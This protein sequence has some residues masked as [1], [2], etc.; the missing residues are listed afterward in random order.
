MKYLVMECH[1][2]YAVVLD[3]E[4]RFLKVANLNYEVGQTVTD[5]I[6][7][8][9]P[10]EYETCME[11]KNEVDSEKPME[12]EESISI[13]SPKIH[14]MNRWM[15]PLVAA[16]ACLCFLVIVGGQMLL[17]PYGSVEMVINPD[18]MI[19]VNR[20]DYVIDVEGLNQDGQDLVADYE[21]RFKKIDQVS[22]ELADRA[23][24]MGYLTEGGTIHLIVTGGKEE[25]KVATEE[26]LVIEL[27][28][29]MG[30]TYVIEVDE[31]REDVVDPNSG[32]III[33][34]DNDWDDDDDSDDADD[35]DNEDDGYDDA[36]DDD[37][38][39]D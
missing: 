21:H 15:K 18:V 36:D 30:D 38:S 9:L 10:I 19:E 31:F 2:G 27:E 11:Y 3:E 26:R 35:D 13:N 22:D 20:L 23:V 29:H 39:E 32:K 16:A 14:K 25:W 1:V 5:V 6:Q 4:G 28:V 37:G 34:I 7:E 33:P 24:E 8:T 12:V 17:T